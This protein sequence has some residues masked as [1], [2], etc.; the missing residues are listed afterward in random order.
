MPVSSPFRF[1]RR[2]RVGLPNIN[3]TNIHQQ[4]PLDIKPPSSRALCPAI[5]VSLSGIIA[6]MPA[7]KNLISALQPHSSRSRQVPGGK[8]SELSEPFPT[9][10]IL[11][12]ARYAGVDDLNQPEMTLC[13][14][15]NLS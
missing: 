10:L 8:L 12:R 3:I 4:A 11:R 14:N 1:R 15:L 5:P 13:Q 6:G 7:E 9:R 2:H